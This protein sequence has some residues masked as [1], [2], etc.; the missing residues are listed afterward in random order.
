MEYND[1]LRAGS[2][3][4][5]L[6][7][8][9]DGVGTKFAGSTIPDLVC[10][11]SGVYTKSGKWSGTEYQLLIPDGVVPLLLLSPLHGTYGD[12]ATSWEALAES[13]DLPVAECERIIREEY[14]STASRLDEVRRFLSPPT[15]RISNMDGST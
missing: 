15:E 4:P 1:K 11:L 3:R 5:R 6:Y 7:L 9:R 8:I 2:R 12:S 14:K 10:V 13:M